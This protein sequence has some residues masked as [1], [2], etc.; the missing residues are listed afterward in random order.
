MWQKAARQLA[1]Y[2]HAAL[3]FVVGLVAV[4]ALGTA[5]LLYR[6]ELA[7]EAAAERERAVLALVDDVSRHGDVL[8]A[9][10]LE[11]QGELDSLATAASIALQHA[12]PAAGAS[13]VVRWVEDFQNPLRQPSGM[14]RVDGIDGPVSFEVPVWRLAP[15]V[16]RAQVMPAIA[17]LLHAQPYQRDLFAR[18]RVLFGSDEGDAGAAHGSGVQAFVVGLAA[19]ATLHLPGRGG[20][21]PVDPRQTSWYQLA[22]GH[23]G[24]V[25]GEPTID[26]GTRRMVVPLAQSIR[27]V[28]GGVLGVTAMLLEL[29]TVIQNLLRHTTD[30]GVR[31][32]LL[33]DSQ[34][35]VIASNGLLHPQLS[36]DG[37]DV[38]N[39]ERFPDEALIEAMAVTDAGF[40]E[41]RVFGVDDLL[42]FDKVLPMGWALV[43]VAEAPH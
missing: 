9:R 28:N 35:R 14:V 30:V 4:A 26:S 20:L 17:R 22:G 11:L 13:E 19:G 41:S 7:L 40:V 36:E 29:D 33:L 38:V 37:A 2:R 39:L 24:P 31:A 16:R 5:A 32:T 6:H 8:Q 3:L 15:G 1:R 34:G 25:W 18:A 21:P 27:D 23:A 12:T 42:V 10:F 43:R